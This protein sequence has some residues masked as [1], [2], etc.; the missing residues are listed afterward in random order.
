MTRYKKVG[1]SFSISTDLR[2]EQRRIE[3]GGAG[4]ERRLHTTSKLKNAGVFVSAAVSSLMPYS[5]QFPRELLDCAHHVSVQLL[6]TAGF[7][8]S[9]PQGVVDRIYRETPM[10]RQLD[11]ALARQ[12]EALDGAELASWG[13]GSKGFIGA[14]LAA[15]RFYGSAPALTEISGQSTLPMILADIDPD[16]R[17]R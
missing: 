1:V 2:D 10:Y 3:R 11:R 8:S 4:P 6:R 14:F 15:R 12:L 13:I 16:Q 9:T 17:M 5:E 7:A